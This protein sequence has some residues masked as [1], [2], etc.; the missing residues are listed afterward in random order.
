M[1]AVTSVVLSG[2]LAR[3]GNDRFNQHRPGASARLRDTALH[4]RVA[5]IESGTHTPGI[6]AAD[7]RL[8]PHTALRYEQPA[9]ALRRYVTSYF[10]LDSEPV[11]PPM[12]SEL[13]LPSWAQI[14]IIMTG[15]PIKV[16]IGN[17]RY[18]PVPAAV[19]YGVTSR[20][21]PVTAQ[22]GVTIGVD[23]SPLGWARLF[24]QSA[25]A[26][27][28]RVTPLD[29]LMSPAMVAELASSLAASD[30]A[31]DVKDILDDFFTRHMA[32]PHR[33]EPLIEQIMRLIAN[34][35]VTSLEAAAADSGVSA[36]T[37]RRT[38]QR[39][40]GFPPKTLI[41]RARFLR[42]FVPMLLTRDTDNKTI[43][44]GYY[45]RS[46]FLRDAERY[47]GMTV[48]RF[49]AVDTPYLDAALRA[50]QMILGAPT[51]ALDEPPA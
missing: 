27:R 6:S 20:A 29:Q 51:P 32:A 49:M 22:G 37:L 14:W 48:K 41:I 46:H 19:L 15:A 47:L 44:A 40:F 5:M 50:R 34:P 30:Q 25:E 35:C 24:H 28:D 42:A 16:V 36:H 23:I 43:P 8:P 45:H 11:D 1:P 2:R 17:R 33:D 21:I 39:Y 38:S 18:E 3:A 26:L 9:P 12:T 4:R 7:F 10:V 13:M 31:L